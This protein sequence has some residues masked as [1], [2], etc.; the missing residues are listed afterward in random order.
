VSSWSYRG[1]ALDTLG[2]VTLVSDSFKMPNKRGENILIPQRDGRRFV[3]KRFEQRGMSLGLEIV[4][5]SIQELEAAIDAVKAL[6]G[7]RDLGNLSQTL[8]SGSVRS[9]EAE[10]TGDLNP[11]RI[12]PM[13]ARMVLEFTMP[14]PF[15]YS[16]VLTTDTHTINASPKTYTINNPGTI[17]KVDPKITLTGPLNGTEITNTVNGVKVKYNAAIT[18]GHYV[19]IDVDPVT[20]E[21]T[22]V[23]DLGANVIGNVTHEG[24]VALFVL[25]SG[26]NPVSV[27]DGV[28]TTGTVKVEFY[29]PNL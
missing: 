13:S 11:A 18:A 10:C 28:A 29:A 6:M 16:S 1:T 27:T 19:V 2:I 7:R 14:N 4:K 20:D 3:E 26:D 8:E 22:A 24:D 17:D 23:D 9:A 5:D 21:Y 15:F 25:D 12:S